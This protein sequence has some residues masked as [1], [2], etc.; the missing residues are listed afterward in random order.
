MLDGIR[1]LGALSVFATHA[2]VLSKSQSAPIYGRI[3]PHVG[4]VGLGM[5]MCVSAF[6]LY[7]P[8]VAARHAEARRPTFRAFA[9]NRVMRVVPAYWSALVLLS[10]YPGLKA[11]FSGD[12]WVY[13][14]FLA[15]LRQ[16]WAFNGL[17]PAWTLHVELVFYLSMATWAAIAIRASKRGGAWTWRREL[18]VLALV[19]A[20]GNLF[21]VLVGV[22]GRHYL[23]ALINFPGY[24]DIFA[25]GMALALVHVR[26]QVGGR[27]PRA[28]APLAKWPLASW[29]LALALF[30]G[31]VIGLDL[32]GDL[33]YPPTYSL[34]QWT[35]RHIMVGFAAL[36]I[37]VPAIFSE[38]SSVVVRFLG[39]SWL[40]WMGLVSYGFYLYHLPIL[41]ELENHGARTWFHPAP[42]LGEVVVG[43]ALSLAL[44]ALS[45]Y[46]IER[47]FLARKSRAR[48]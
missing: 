12:A 44:A 48:A 15:P 3:A 30:L 24:V 2:A 9:R 35:A 6:L 13:F 11:V 45:F 26:L 18:A 47:P 7:R 32:P 25:L 27:L 1:A 4:D 5:L 22:E 20:G 43:V 38:G 33:A 19:W 39:W 28:I 41:R 34:G 21:R 36:L 14:G 37:V 8:F 17:T 16:E 31:V 10:L 46:L 29:T 23:L 42:L 40:R